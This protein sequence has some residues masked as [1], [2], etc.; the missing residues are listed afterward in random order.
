MPLDAKGRKVRLLL[1]W[2]GLRGFRW[3]GKRKM[4]VAG[5]EARTRLL[6]EPL[7]PRGPQPVLQRLRRSVEGLNGSAEPPD[8]VPG[9]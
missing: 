2:R 3:N 4:K 9:L 6:A 1:P 8:G 7:S 5:W